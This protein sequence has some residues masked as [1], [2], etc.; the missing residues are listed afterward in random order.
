M[1]KK[2]AEAEKQGEREEDQ[3]RAHPAR[4]ELTSERK[5]HRALMILERIAADINCIVKQVVGEAP[6]LRP[7]PNP[8]DG[9]A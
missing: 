4:T 7:K 9:K 8:L 3:D 6:E 2:A 1:P 5:S